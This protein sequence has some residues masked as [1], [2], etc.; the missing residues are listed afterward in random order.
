MIHGSLFI[1][2]VFL[3]C[4]PFIASNDGIILKYELEKEL[5]GSGR[6]LFFGHCSSIYLDGVKKDFRVTLE[7]QISRT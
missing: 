3:S 4:I 1:L 6:D 5:R 7:S 2:T